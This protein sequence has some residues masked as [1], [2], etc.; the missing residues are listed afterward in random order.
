[1]FLDGVCVECPDGLLR[2]RWARAL[3]SAELALPTRV[4]APRIARYLERQSILK[5]DAEN[6]WLAGDGFDAG[7]LEQFP[8]LVDRLPYRYRAPMLGARC[9]R[10]RRCRRMTSPSMMGP[11]IWPVHACPQRGCFRV[12]DDVS[13]LGSLRG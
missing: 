6:S 2:F 11:A 9:S 7:T 3:S 13:K 1:M 10:R 5:R 4:L 12:R 8:E